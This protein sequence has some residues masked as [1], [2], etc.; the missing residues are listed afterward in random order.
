MREGRY[1]KTIEARKHTLGDLIDR[2]IRDVLPSKPKSYNKQKIQLEW[3]KNHLGHQLLSALTPAL[4]AEHRDLLSSQM[5]YRKTKR[6]PA[7]VVRYLAAL[8]HA[9]STAVKEW[10]W[11]E[12]NP[13]RKVSK[14]KEPR[15]RVRFLSTEER[16]RLLKA[17]KIDPC[18][19]LY[20]V[21]VI[22]MSTGMRQMEIL[23]LRWSDVS[24]DEVECSPFKVDHSV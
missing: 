8:S 16:P 4:I 19:Y 11:L 1:F 5:T 2:Y 24:L 12:D 17:C 10:G 14:P 15:G 7:T 22:G 6:S 23:N 20:T 18:P 13:M 3:W 9:L 21:V